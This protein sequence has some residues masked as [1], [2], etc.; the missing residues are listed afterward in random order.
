MI[1]G[2]LS[3]RLIHLTRSDSAQEAKERFSAILRGGR[4]LGSTRDIRGGAKCICFSEAPLANIV[5]SL[6]DSARNG[7]RYAPFGVMVSKQW[8]FSKGGRPVIYQSEEE[9]SHL[10]ESLQF[11]HVRYEPGSVDYTFEREWRVRTDS[12]KLDP[13]ETTV[14]VPTRGWEQRLQQ[15][16]VMASVT[17]GSIVGLPMLARIKWHFVVLEDL[18]LEGFE[19]E[20]F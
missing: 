20:G 3:N 17:A 12:L 10:P 4:L 16:D 7:F 14:V 13:S 18:G 11:R 5:Q 6:G 19:A 1:R 2:D 9:F 15:Q 8:L